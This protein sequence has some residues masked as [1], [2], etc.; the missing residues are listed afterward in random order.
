MK[1]SNSCASVIASFCGLVADSKLE[2]ATNAKLLHK[3]AVSD[4]V[5]GYR[6]SWATHWLNKSKLAFVR[7]PVNAAPV[8]LT[9]IMATNEKTTCSHRLPRGAC[10]HSCRAGFG[11]DRFCLGHP[12]ASG[13]RRVLS[14]NSAVVPLRNSVVWACVIVSSFVCASITQGRPDLFQICD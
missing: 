6:M 10:N 5:I 2:S 4:P 14:R 8:A 7:T 11:K 12:V 13:L 1:A 3:P 9:E